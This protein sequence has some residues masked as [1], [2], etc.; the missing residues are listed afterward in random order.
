MLPKLSFFI[1]FGKL[2]AV[3][4]AQQPASSG[5]NVSCGSSALAMPA[6]FAI[7][8]AAGAVLP[9]DRRTLCNAAAVHHSLGKGARSRI[10]QSS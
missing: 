4:G 5:R 10:H 3:K 8:T 1:C 2:L 6:L 9:A 7:L